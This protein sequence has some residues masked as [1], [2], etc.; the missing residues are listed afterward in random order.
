MIRPNICKESS[1]DAQSGLQ[2]NANTHVILLIFFFTESERIS[3]NF[4]VAAAD[5]L[6]CWL[7]KGASLRGFRGRRWNPGLGGT[8]SG[9]LLWKWD[10]RSVC[11]QSL[12]LKWQI[13]F[14]LCDVGSSKRAGTFVSGCVQAC[15]VSLRDSGGAGWALAFST[16]VWPCCYFWNGEKWWYLHLLDSLKNKFYI[17]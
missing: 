12:P 4:T 7:I 10:P 5:A 11:W 9:W 14:F 6:N 16:P 15:A 2:H 8:V 17:P 1:V 3:Q 13:L